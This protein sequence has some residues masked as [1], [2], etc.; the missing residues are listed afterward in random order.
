MRT[1]EGGEEVG[2][3][4]EGGEGAEAVHGEG[5]GELA[6]DVNDGIYHVD[7]EVLE[8]HRVEDRDGHAKEMY[9]RT[10]MEGDTET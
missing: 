1:I 7:G 9:Q 10:E 8:H 4:K 5:S 6:G 3:G 2:E